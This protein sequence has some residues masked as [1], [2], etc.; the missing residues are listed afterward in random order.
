MARFVF[1]HARESMP[2]R[3]RSK[4]NFGELIIGL[5]GVGF[6]IVAMFSYL[7][8]F[9]AM[10]TV[11]VLESIALKVIGCVAVVA[12]IAVCVLMW[13]SKSRRSKS[14]DSD[15]STW[16]PDAT[17]NN[18]F[19]VETGLVTF[20][21]KPVDPRTEPVSL[22]EAEIFEQIRNIDWYQFEKLVALTYRKLGYAVESRG[23]ANPDGGIDLIIKKG[24]DPI[25]VQCKHWQNRDIPVATVREFVGALADARIKTGIFV[26]LNGYTGD[27]KQLAERHNIAIINQTRLAEMLEQADVRFDPEFLSL[28]S[29]T[30]KVCPKCESEL[31]IRK[32]KRGENAG[33]EF[34]GCSSFPDCRFQMPIR[35]QL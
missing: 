34:W 25:A 31:V 24:G 19:R 2:S 17:A 6:V 1:Y 3:R 16:T 18:C 13:L 9:G 26:T 8:G 32:T 22:T 29:D 11:A 28:L 15:R 5:A 14:A 33:R 30:R 20:A 23:G 35:I 7:H 4:A 27:A 21:H 10:Q 12:V